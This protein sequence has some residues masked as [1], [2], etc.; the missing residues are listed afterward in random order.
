[1]NFDR[2]F[3]NTL[4]TLSV[5]LVEKAGSG[6]LGMPLGSAPMAYELFKNHIDIYPKESEWFNRDRFIYSS[7]HGTPLLYSLYHLFGYDISMDDLKD[8][9]QLDSITPGHPESY[10]TDGVDATTGPL[11]QGFAMAVGFAI[12]EM[13]LAE[14]YN[15]KDLEIINHNTY[16]ICGDGDLMEGVALEAASIAGKLELNKL[17]VLYD[18]NDVVLDGDVIDSTSDKIKE[19]F[20]S[21]NWE[22]IFVK[23]GEDIKEVGK[24]I[25]KAK[26]SDKPVI[27]EVKNTIGFGTLDA[28]T[29]NAH[30][31][32]LGEEG[33]RYLREQIKWEYTDVFYIPYEIAEFKDK[34]LKESEEKYKN[35]IDIKNKYKEKYPEDYEKLF[36]LD[37]KIEKLDF[38]EF[39]KFEETKPIRLASEDVL[40]FVHDKLNCM[41]GGSA[42]LAK[43]NK[44]K[45]RNEGYFSKNEAKNGNIAFGVREFGMAAI[46]NGISLHG[47]L[48]S[49]GS[50]FLVFS[51]YMKSAI[52]HAAL[53]RINPIF[54]FTHDTLSIGPDGPTHQPIEQIA[55]LR[56]LPNLDI[57]RPAD[58]NEVIYAWEYALKNNKPTVLINARQELSIIKNTSYENL[59]KGAYIVKESEGY[60]ATIIATGSEVSLAL[61]VSQ[62]MEDKNIKLRV[63]NMPSWELFERE[64]KEYKN[65]I[66]DNKKPVFSIEAASGFGW[67]RYTKNT[68]NIFCTNEFGESGNGNELYKRRGFSVENISN[69]IYEILNNR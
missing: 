7:G 9:R 12:A 29:N 21:M 26:T 40:N 15:K 30:A 20:E 17:I 41:L 36:D 69:N 10:I 54:I 1:M 47:G 50:T 68:E 57:I 19:K 34:Y 3:I 24:A 66:I 63:V 6:H 31:D 53:Q 27:I 64:D 51:E 16:V 58:P 4:R 14:K 67:E 32:P 43:S 44:V 59:K 22:H 61:K 8:Y 62:Y 33:I 55:S 23:D 38:S 5:D 18:S 2:Q 11:G 37:E 46:V 13:N 56:A 28:G 35:W 49:F 25:D 60:D 45:L 42:D 65:S 48:K 52:R 39:G